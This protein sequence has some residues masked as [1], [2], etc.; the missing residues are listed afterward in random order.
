MEDYV[1]KGLTKVAMLSA[2]MSLAKVMRAGAKS[3]KSAAKPA[4]HKSLKLKALA[5]KAKKAK[6][7]AKGNATYGM[8]GQM[9]A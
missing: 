4:A 2:P 9:K 5:A 1:I 6:D 7:A 8:P 3:A